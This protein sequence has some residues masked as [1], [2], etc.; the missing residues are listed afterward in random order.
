MSQNL[1]FISATLD[2]LSDSYNFNE[3]QLK[4]DEILKQMKRAVSE[5]LCW[6]TDF[7]PSGGLH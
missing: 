6:F 2:F 4:H 5:T 1:T 3:K 7:D